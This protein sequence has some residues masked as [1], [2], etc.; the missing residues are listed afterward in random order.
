MNYEEAKSQTNKRLLRFAWGLEIFFCIAGV[1]IAF[2]L[3]FSGLARGD[4]LSS[5][6]F[7][8]WLG[9]GVVGIVLCAIAL[10]ELVKIPTVQGILYAKSLKTKVLCSLFLM[11]ICFLTFETMTQGLEQ[12]IA[13]REIAIEKPRIKLISFNER[14]VLIDK[15]I[16]SIKS[17]TPE[18]I[19]KSAKK[20]LDSQLLVL[21]GQISDLEN[22]LVALRAPKDSAEVTEIKRQIV[23]L[24]QSK[25]ESKDLFTQELSRLSE[26]LNNLNRNEQEE[27]KNSIFKGSIRSN[28]EKQRSFIV[29]RKGDLDS[30]YRKEISD[31]DSLIDQLGK[32]ILSLSQVDNES[33]GE[34]KEINSTIQ[35]L[36]QEKG[37]LITKS[38]KAIE[39]DL[40]TQERKAISIEALLDEKGE[41]LAE[42]EVMRNQINIESNKSF[43]H[44]IASRIFGKD[45]AADLTKE[46]VSLVSLIFII[47]VASIVSISGP[48]MAFMSVS[49]SIEQTDLKRKSRTRS[50]F[51]RMLID[52][53]K[54]LRKPKVVT[55]TEEKEVI[56]EVVK[57]V[58]VDRPVFNTVEV[59]TPVE[60]TR[61]VGVPVPTD[62]KNLPEFHNDQ[63]GQ[64]TP[65]KDLIGV[66]K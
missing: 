38:N 44:R 21:E 39:K 52:L 12:N 9:F 34:I 37:R 51:R 3:A 59:P 13:N 18:Q 61:F 6:G 10:T 33:Q 19:K 5:I 49:N 4:E 8:D 26:E 35:R 62:P 64:F 15:E 54:R 47:S 1:L 57:E 53:R 25:Q 22:R 32:K 43:I 58:K 36:N 42:A 50:T 66:T 41:L 20:G 65:L 29:S 14:S 16:S 27:L 23:A 2:S 24:N 11:A 17:L 30:S 56:K 55:K 63:E 7:T 31:Y 28:Y 40:I 60:V 46:Q 48:I 45:S